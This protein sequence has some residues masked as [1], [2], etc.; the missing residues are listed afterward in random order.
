MSVVTVNGKVKKEELGITL[1]HEHLFVDL[2]YIYKETSEIMQRE[3]GKEKLNIKNLNI[4]RRNPLLIEDNLF[5]SNEKLI[6]DE[7]LEFKKAGGKTIVD[8]TT[9]DIGR[10]PLSIKNISNILG[11]NV[12]MGCGY[13]MKSTLPSD[14]FKRKDTD[15]TKELIKEINYGVRGTGIKPGIIGEVG[16][17]HVIGE[18]EERLLRIVAEV[19]K[20]SGLPIS[21]HI[22]AVPVLGSL[23]KLQGLKVLKILEKAGV[24][25]D[26]VIICHV[27]AKI[28]MAYIRDV[29]DKGSYIEFDHFGPDYYIED[30]DFLLDRDF[31]RINA[32]RELIGLGYLKKILISQDI[33]LKTDLISYGGFG[34]GHILNNLVPIMKKK[35]IDQDAI[36]TIMVKNPQEILDIDEKY[37]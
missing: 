31:D 27:D 7:L 24:E 9:D 36:N 21:V 4:V 19:H 11:I 16:M 32:I 2:R 26:R 8:L 14:I 15:L 5:L 30:S 18:W 3:K 35:G 6:L 1:P 29:L 17:S 22:L 23:G 13:Y 25:L 20:E 12:V 33:C 10:S 37:F 28:D 34:Y